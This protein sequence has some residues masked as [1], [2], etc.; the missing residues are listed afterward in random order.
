MPK[1]SIIMPVY[2][3]EKYL[4]ASIQSV[5]NQTYKD[6]ELILVDDG[7]PDRCPEICDS[8]AAR[9]ENVTVIHTENQ[10][11][12]K[13]RDTGVKNATGEY[14]LFVDSDDTIH[15]DLL[16]NVVSEAEKSNADVTIFGIHVVTMIDG[17]F[18]GEDFRCHKA[19]FYEN[20]DEVEKQFVYMNE[21]LMWNH[22][23]DKL[24]KKTVITDNHVTG[25][26]FYDGVCE[27][28]MF[29]LDLFPFVNSICVIEGY[30][31]EYAIRNT[32]STVAKY[33]P[34]RYEM[35]YGRFQ[36][37][38]EIMDTLK[39]EYRSD[40]MLYDLYCTFIVWAYEFMFHRDCTLS[41]LERYKYIRNTF[42]IR[43]E[44]K[45]FCDAAERFYMTNDAYQNTSGT[46]KKVLHYIL[47][48]NYFMAWFYHIIALKRNQKNA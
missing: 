13:S 3:V 48:N 11:R 45:V 4:D 6:F 34:N 29:L 23:V 2:K 30:F 40:V 15:S 33:I 9:Y 14:I 38:K 42:S 21:N 5:L 1:V 18:S 32:I 12:A 46:T 36:K 20:R 8:Y 16:E 10:N 24:I 28:T 43:K 7:S 31:Y 27:D 17:I 19:D 22:P 37:T 26:S 47:H 35:L 44:D 39:P 41:V 25:K